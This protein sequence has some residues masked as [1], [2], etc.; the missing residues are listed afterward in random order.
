MRFLLTSTTIFMF[1][2]CAAATTFAPATARA[3]DWSIGITVPGV[4]IVV[5][6]PEYEYVPEPPEYYGPAYYPPRYYGPPV[7]GY[8]GYEP[9]NYDP[10]RE[11]RHH[12]GDDSSDDDDG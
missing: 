9:G 11:R 1:W 12:E 3:D 8:G 4:I 2:L 6:T 10:P 5:P 7:V